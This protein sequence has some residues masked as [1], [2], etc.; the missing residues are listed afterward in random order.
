MPTIKLKPKSPEFEGAQTQGKTVTCEIPGCLLKGDHK[1]PKNRALGE[2]YHFCYEHVRDYNAAWNFFEGL[3]EAEIQEHMRRSF[4]GDRP[5][6]KYGVGADAL[7][8]LQ[9][10]AWQAYHNTE[11]EPPRSSKKRSGWEQRKKDFENK[12]APEIEAMAI[13]GLEPPLQLPEIKARYRALVKAYH[14]DHNPDPEAA[15]M[16]KAINMA[17]TLL[18]AA[19]ERYDAAFSE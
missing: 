16:I 10:K 5:T 13:M 12:H 1:A 14:P 3:S 18:K 8:E 15:E 4:F 9:R 19:H 6:W 11:Q 2:Y 17:Y 7:D